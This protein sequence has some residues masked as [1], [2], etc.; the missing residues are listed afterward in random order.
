MM[1]RQKNGF[2]IMAL[3]VG[4]GMS[5]KG[6][7][8]SPGQVHNPFESSTKKSVRGNMDKVKK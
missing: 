6:V 1:D 2:K 5:L 4:T 3:R 8:K 7:G